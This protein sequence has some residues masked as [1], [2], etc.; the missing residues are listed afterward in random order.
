[1]LRKLPPLF[2]P[3]A[4]DFFYWML[5]E[6]R[7]HRVVGLLCA[8]GRVHSIRLSPK[9]LCRLLTMVPYSPVYSSVGGKGCFSLPEVTLSCLESSQ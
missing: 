2:L 7:A 9:R 6:D 1:M 5:G 8:R 3:F 4:G